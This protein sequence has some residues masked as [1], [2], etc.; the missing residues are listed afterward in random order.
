MATRKSTKKTATRK[1]TPA[2]KPATIPAR[3]IRPGF[4]SHTELAS[5]DP[6]ATKAWCL[7]ALGWKFGE[8]MPTPAGPYYMWSFDNDSGVGIRANNPPE[9]AGTV[10]Y[11]EVPDIHAA[12][13]R[14]LKAGATPML[15][16]EEIPGGNRWLAI[17][18]AP[19]GVTIGL[20]GPK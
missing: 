17:V 12:Y 20:W 9:P 16:P 5:R 1:K 4:I 6:A 15:P 14:A 10:P 3:K 18:Q 7:E 11:A 13:D 2:K 19:G 8:P